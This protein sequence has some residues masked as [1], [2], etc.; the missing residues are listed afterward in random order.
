MKRDEHGCIRQETAEEV[1]A[2]YNEGDHIADE[3]ASDRALRDSMQEQM[4]I[5]LDMAEVF[6]KALSDL[7]PS[8]MAFV[9]QYATAKAKYIIARDNMERCGFLRRMA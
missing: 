6:R 5:A 1:D 4:D 3:R 7:A 9:E 8:T 2:R